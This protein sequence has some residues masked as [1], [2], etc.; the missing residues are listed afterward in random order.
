[1]AVAT[2][3]S[4]VGAVQVRDRA[5]VRRQ[6]KLVSLFALV[7]VALLVF[8]WRVDDFHIVYTLGERVTLDN[9]SKT[10]NARGI[11]VAGLVVSAAAVLLAAVNRV[12]KGALGWV[13]YF[14]V[15]L[16]FFS[17]FT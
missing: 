2:A 3:I 11:A 17:G 9:P 14:L 1:M 15:G 12:P 7:L 5:D 16:A 13:V 8:Y 6:T 4:D 10:I